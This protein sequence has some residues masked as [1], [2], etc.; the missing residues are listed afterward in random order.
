MSTGQFIE[1]LFWGGLAEA[2]IL[3]AGVPTI[4]WAHS[5]TAVARAQARDVN[6]II[7]VARDATNLLDDIYAEIKTGNIVAP[8]EIENRIL[9]VKIQSDQ[10]TRRSIR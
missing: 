5:R 6:A 2:L 3:C 4:L 9:D 7:D 8:K 1:V 10:A